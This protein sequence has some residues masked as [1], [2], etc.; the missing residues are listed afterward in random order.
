[1]AN[2]LQT[3]KAL[4]S[5]SSEPY[6]KL[7]DERLAKHKYLSG[8][9]IGILDLSLYG[10][11]YVFS[12]YPMMECIKAMMDQSPLFADWFKDMN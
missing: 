9:E 8:D 1:M 4:V 12:K 5:D 10:V 6:L 11:T 7:I 3:S 2:K